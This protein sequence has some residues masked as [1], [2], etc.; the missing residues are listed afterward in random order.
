MR[1]SLIGRLL[2]VSVL[3][4]VC[5]I[6]ATAWL[7]ARTTSGAIQQEQ[8]RALA[9]D[10]KIY[11]ALL[12]YAATHK[13][14]K[15]VGP[16]L[17]NH[18]EFSGRRV[19]LTAPDGKPIG[20][21]GSGPL[22]AKASA[23]VDPLAVDADLT[24][25][26]DRIAP[27]ATGPFT[28]PPDELAFLTGVADRV[29]DCVRT[30][31]GFGS[32]VTAPN[33]HPQVTGPDAFVVSRCQTK[34]LVNPTKTEQAALDQLDGLANACLSRRGL[35]PI[36]V[37]LDFTWRETLT[38]VAA[39]DED[40]T[41][42]NQSCVATARHE[43]LTAF[44]APPALLYITQPDGAAP[45]G[46]TLSPDNWRRIALVAGGVLLLAVLVTVLAGARLV[47]PLR[48]LTSA[49]RLAG[50]G[51]APARV[52]VKGKDEIGRLAV[53]FNEMSAA[54]QRLEDNRKTMVSDIAHE[55]RTPLSNIR[56]WLEATQ[57][58]VST[59]D[60][61][62]AASLLEEAMHLQHIVDDLFDLSQA[63][64]GALRLHPEPLDVSDLLSQVRAAH[65]A[66]AAKAGVTLATEAE[67]VELTADPVRLRQVLDNLVSNAV[68]H[69]P[70]G[71]SVTVT[72]RADG[73]EVAFEIADTGSGIS[74]EDLPSVFDRFWR[75]DKART[76]QSGGSGLGLA[77][78]R[79]LA[80]AHGG[81]VTAAGAPGQGAVFTLRLPAR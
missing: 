12:T 81:T 11:Q 1:R 39:P 14:W 67:D 44:V 46:F 35:P 20:D 5:S 24:T 23:L 33:G 3:V 41:E 60:D 78:V 65:S 15:D 54:R 61:E 70:A 64:A 21:S 45:S 72:A 17:A 47:R 80:E 62:L 19:T 59:L 79:K 52:E 77:I 4:A 55:L 37:K 16:V 10:S 2:A 50:S 53:A 22:P 48:A 31:L 29:L 32:I 30:R 42:A 40:N 18:A 27:Q 75:A 57:D 25:S 51:D 66:R 8:G 34:D 28:L 56:G 76:R 26:A 71:G 7:A 58:G 68:R 38:R 6:A 73:D 36:S 63:D 69:T 74:A 43:Q 49:A 13:S 9:D